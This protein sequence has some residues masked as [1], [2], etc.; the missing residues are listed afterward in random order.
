VPLLNDG[1]TLADRFGPHPE[2]P[3]EAAGLRPYLTGSGQA[4]FSAVWLAFTHRVDKDLEALLRTAEGRNGFAAVSQLAEFRK[5]RGE[6]AAVRA[7]ALLKVCQR[8]VIDTMLGAGDP[9]TSVRA[10]V[11]LALRG[12]A[13]AVSVALEASGVVEMKWLVRKTYPTSKWPPPRSTT[14][15]TAS[16]AAHPAQVPGTHRGTPDL[17]FCAADP[18]VRPCRR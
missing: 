3:I 4:A 2:V 9:L 18:P 6:P 10:S 5:E 11:T 13:A 1:K 14:L 15:M 7:A 17:A 12:D 8:S 16:R